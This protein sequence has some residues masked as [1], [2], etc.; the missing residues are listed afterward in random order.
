MPIQYNGNFCAYIVK[1]QNILC[2][3]MSI[4][5][6]G[7]SRDQMTRYTEFI[8]IFSSAYDRIF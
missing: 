3:L 7:N 2:E 4:S 8:T 6:V 1:K 5:S